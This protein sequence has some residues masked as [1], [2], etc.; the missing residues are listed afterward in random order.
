VTVI[1]DV[2]VIV[3]AGVSASG[4]AHA[5]KAGQDGNIPSGDFIVDVGSCNITIAAPSCIRIRTRTGFTGG[6]DPQPYTVIA[7]DDINAAINQAQTAATNN[8]KQALQN[9]L[10]VNEYM[11]GDLQCSITGSS[12]DRKAGEQAGAVNASATAYC[13]VT[14]ST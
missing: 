8:A 6:V 2:D 7:Q 14:A 5:A 12:A 13:S 1:L 3:Q 10:Q 11:L 9:Q 4:Q